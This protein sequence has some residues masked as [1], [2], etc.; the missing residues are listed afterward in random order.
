MPC[1]ISVRRL[2]QA[3]VPACAAL[4]RTVGWRSLETQWAMLL[5][6]GDGFGA[7]VD[8]SLAGTVIINRFGDTLASVAMMVVSPNN[9]RLGVGRQLMVAGLE[10]ARH[11]SVFLYATDVGRILYER[12][13][14]VEAGASRRMTGPPVKGGSM[15]GARPMRSAD[16][17]AV[18]ALDEEAHGARRCALI[19]ALVANVD[20]ATVVEEHGEITAYGLATIKDGRRVLGPIVA[21]DDEATRSVA[22]H[23]C[24]G[25]DLPLVLDLDRDDDALYSWAHQ[26]GLTIEGTTTMMLRGAALPGRRNMIRALAGRA[27]G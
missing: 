17:P 15:N 9:Q 22:T 19:D 24:E 11:A 13:G 8:G 4:A 16:L 18:Y 7:E 6:V 12:L 20:R 25:S 1:V 26:G 3:D 10:H 5:S 23:L 27:F 14:F 21:R 2:E